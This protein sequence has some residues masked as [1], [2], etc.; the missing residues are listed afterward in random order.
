MKEH[1]PLNISIEDLNISD[2]LVL[3]QQIFRFFVYNIEE[4]SRKDRLYCFKNKKDTSMGPPMMN[5]NPH[6]NLPLYVLALN[7]INTHWTYTK[8]AI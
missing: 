7:R 2:F 8:C 4:F 5:P 3:K 1:K 6:I